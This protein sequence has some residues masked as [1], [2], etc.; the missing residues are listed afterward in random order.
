[1]TERIRLK[2]KSQVTIPKSII[3][4]LNLTEGDQFE[5]EVD[6]KG[7]IILEPMISIP[8][9]QTWFWMDVWQEGERE[10]EEDIKSGRVHRFD[11]ADDLIAWMDPDDDK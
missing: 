8:R 1:M 7:R 4:K 10:A 2:R 6:E 9:S 11:S 3:D 5:V